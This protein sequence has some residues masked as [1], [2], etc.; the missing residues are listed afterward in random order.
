MDLPSSMK[1]RACCLLVTALCLNALVR[2]GAQASARQSIPKLPDKPQVRRTF[3]LTKFYDTPSPLPPGKPG[4]LIRKE[5][6]E[7]YD[8]PPGVLAVRILYHSRSAIGGDVATSGVV[9]YPDAT[10]PAGGW[11]VIAWAHDLNG[12][13]RQCAPSLARNLQHGPFLS[14]YVNLGYAVVAT[15]YTGLG[16][17][18]H[19]AFS[20]MQSNAVDVIYSIPAARAAVPQLGSR[21]IAIGSGDGGLAVAG[22]AG[23]EH[24]IRDQNYLGGIAI[25]GLS[26]LQDHYEHPDDRALL[27]LAYGIKTVYPEFDIGNMLTDKALSLYPRVEQACGEPGT[28]TKLSASEMLKPNWG[29]NRFVKQY[30]S[31]NRPGERPAYAA[32]LVI[33]SEADPAVPIPKTARVIARMCE[34]GDQ[35]QFERY[36]DPDP[37]SVIGES[38]RDQISWI[39]GRFAGRPARSNCSEQR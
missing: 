38:V 11:P 23:L 18:F 15:D 31:R 19:S 9:L 16:T 32:L 5:D 27:F 14:M 12:V 37:G 39:Q 6:F 25:S 33:A 22:V 2:A 21:W 29:N 17:N 35:V 28:G 4:E 26:D 34:Q 7:E 36:A 13:A 8:L 20:D 1:F 3:P 30:F 24:D 10:A